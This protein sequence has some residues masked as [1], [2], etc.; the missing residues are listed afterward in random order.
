MRAYELMAI[1][2][3]DVVDETIQGHLKTLVSESVEANGGSVA[4]VDNWGKRRFAYRINHKWEGTY[5][6]LEILLP[7]GKDL[8]GPDRALRLADDVVRH[9]IIRLPEGEATK[10]GLLGAAASA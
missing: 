8:S 2:D 10:R 9:K 3:A 5:V 1:F 6:V 7:E 4:S